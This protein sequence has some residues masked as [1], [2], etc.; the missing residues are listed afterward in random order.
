MSD[1]A[2]RCSAFTSKSA[3]DRTCPASDG[4]SRLYFLSPEDFSTQR[5]LTV[6]RYGRFLNNINELEF[7]DGAIWA[8]VF[9]DWSIVKISPVTGC[10]EA[11]A[12]L[13]P[14]RARMNKADQKAINDGAINE[15]KL[16]WLERLL[17]LSDRTIIVA[18]AVSPSYVPTTPP[19]PRAAAS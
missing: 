6:T 14:L 16:R 17:M 18:S 11:I 1:A 15:K 4:S 2:A 9:E 19:S 3:P 5:V 7:V 13:K 12:D 10:V 8:N